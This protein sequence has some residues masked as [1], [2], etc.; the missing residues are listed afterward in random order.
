MSPPAH[1]ARCPDLD[2]P[3]LRDADEEAVFAR[4]VG[5]GPIDPEVAARVR[6][7]AEQVTEGLRQAV[8]IVDDETFQSL[9]DDEA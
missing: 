9:L 4:F 8:G 3:D 2:D 1:I 7:R 6:A 5:G